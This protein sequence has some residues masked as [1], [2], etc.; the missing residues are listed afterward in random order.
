MNT[1]AWVLGTVTAV[2]A[3]AEWSAVWLERP[4]VRRFTKPATLVGLIGV[5]LA[6]DPVDGRI[7]TV[8]VIGLVLSL[9]GDVFLLG[10]EKWFLWG[11]A[12]FLLAHIA[13]IVGLQ[14]AP[15]SL[16][17]SMLGLGVVIAAVAGVGSRIMQA[18][19]RSGHTPM[20][21]AVLAY[22]AIIS[23]MVVSAAG[24]ASLWAVFGATLFYVSDAVLAWNRFV[25]RRRFGPITV[26]V[27]YHLGQ[28]G[29]VA[30][31]V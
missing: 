17:W 2:L 30:W 5:A 24:T 16:G 27:T 4:A 6:L 14:L 9:A 23:L 29:L 31:L 21:I 25:G 26:M 28:A 10:D 3:V 13:Y 15:T 11:L 22:L 19:N 1:L 7:R 18:V 8:M 20:T 12:S